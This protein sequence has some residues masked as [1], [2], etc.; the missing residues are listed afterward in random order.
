MI[1]MNENDF[2]RICE[3]IY[4]DRESICMHNPIGTSEEI[5]LWM[6][7]GCLICYLSLTEVETPCFNGKPNA[8]IYRNAILFVLKPRRTTDFEAEVY[9]EKFNGILVN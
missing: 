3:E 5:L 1:K 6:L 9:L 2:A 8:E 7:L 4:E